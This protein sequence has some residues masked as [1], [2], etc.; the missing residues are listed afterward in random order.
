MLIPTLLAC[1]LAAAGSLSGEWWRLRRRWSP[2][3][4][5]SYGTAALC[6]LLIVLAQVAVNA[7]LAEDGSATPALSL[8][9]G[10]LIALVVGPALHAVAWN[11]LVLA[12]DAVRTAAVTGRRSPRG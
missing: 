7:V 2:Q 3:I 4:A 1:L 11:L 10:L 9:H 12:W 8:G 6:A 5:P